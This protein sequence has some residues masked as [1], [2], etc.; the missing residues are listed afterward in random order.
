MSMSQQSRMAPSQ[1]KPLEQMSDAE[2]TAE[3]DR[4]LNN[5]Q[6][7][8]GG[9]EAAPEAPMEAAPATQP[10]P[11]APAPAAPAPTGEM[12]LGVVPA[13]ELQ[14][15]TAKMVAM[16]LLESATT[17][18]SPDLVVLFQAIIDAIDPG[19]YNLQQPE[20]LKEFIN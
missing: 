9:A 16:G 7:V 18:L 4:A 6:S 5:L 8:V 11:A 15:A 19:L 3:L 20:Q 14:Q 13:E 17:E 1:Q 2:L 12:M 10:A